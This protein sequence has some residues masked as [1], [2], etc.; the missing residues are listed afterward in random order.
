MNGAS[1]AGRLALAA[2]GAAAAAGCA[3]QF[4]AGGGVAIPEGRDPALVSVS[5]VSAGYVGKEH[6][7]RGGAELGERSELRHGSSWDLGVQLG[8]VRNPEPSAPIGGSIYGS[9]GTPLR[10]STFFA[11]GELYWGVGAEL[12]FWLRGGRGP[13]DLNAGQWL[14]V[15]KPELFIFGRARFHRLSEDPIAGD[16]SITSDVI[17]GTGLQLRAISDL[18]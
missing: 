4:Q 14:L 18:F 9:F 8:Y 1:S 3:A 11:D 5:D 6:S 2:L 7:F 16:D 15:R 17:L 12:Q 10:Q 13:E